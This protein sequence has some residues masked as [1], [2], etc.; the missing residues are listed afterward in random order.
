MNLPREGNSPY[1]GKID[2]K[3]YLH[4]NLYINKR[5]GVAHG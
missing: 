4:Y 2:K 1:Y 3:S 5:E